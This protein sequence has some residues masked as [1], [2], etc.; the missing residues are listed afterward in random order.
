MEVSS[1]LGLRLALMDNK[2]WRADSFFLG[3]FTILANG[4]FRSD[5]PDRRCH[6]RIC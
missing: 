6:Q 2:F 5:S 4:G 3:F 1:E